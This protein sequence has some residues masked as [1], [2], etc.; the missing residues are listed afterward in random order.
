MWRPFVSASPPRVRRV[1]REVLDAVFGRAAR[2]EARER[3]ASP[4][5]LVDERGVDVDAA[6][7]PPSLICVSF[8]F[9]LF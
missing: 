4:A 3:F 2:R 1:R 9:A 5:R 6:R 7:V 8:L